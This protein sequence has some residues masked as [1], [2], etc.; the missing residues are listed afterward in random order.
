MGTT[1]GYY[2]TKKRAN[3]FI[4]S[5]RHNYVTLDNFR[6]EVKVIIKNLS[7]YPSENKN[8]IRFFKKVSD[9]LKHDINNCYGKSKL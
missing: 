1:K 8:Q 9:C 5:L 7:E 4:K 6:N 3:D 2:C